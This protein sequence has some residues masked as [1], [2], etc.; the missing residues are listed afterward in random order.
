MNSKYK[1]KTRFRVLPCTISIQIR[2]PGSALT[3][4]LG[5]ILL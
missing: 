2:E 5:L 3:H 4:F 1:E